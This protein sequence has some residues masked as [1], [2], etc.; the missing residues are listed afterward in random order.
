MEDAVSPAPQRA[1][2][3][4]RPAAWTPLPAAAVVALLVVALVTTAAAV[5]AGVR[6]TSSAMV[7]ACDGVNLRAGTSTFAPIKARLSTGVTLTVTGS[8][9]GSAWRAVCAGS[10]AGSGW[11]RVSHVNGRSVASLYG[12]SVLYAATGVLKNAPAA[13]PTPAPTPTPTPP[14]TTPAPTPTPAPSPSPTPSPPGMTI[15]GPTVTFFGRGWGHGV[16]LSQY[17]ARGRAFAGQSAAAILAHY[18]PGTTPW[19]IPTTTSVRVLLVDDLVPTTAS[20]V[21]VTGRGGTW[22][23]DGIAT[24]FP[25][26]GRLQLIPATGATTTWRLVVD[27]A[28]GKVLRQ[29]EAPADLRVRGTTAATLFQLPAAS[30]TYDLFRGTLRILRSGAKVDVVNELPMESYLRGVVPAEMSSSW[31]V[32]ARIAQTIAA[33]SYAAYR[34]RPGVSTFDVYPDTRS[35]V[36]L[37]VRV[38]TGAAS[39]VVADTSGRVLRSGTAIA[40]TLFH[41]T[42]G[43]AT[44]N[45]ENVFVS[46]TGA[47]VAGPV[48]YLRGS[49]DRDAK[50]VP[51]DA[52]SPYATWQ[53]RSYTLAQLSAILAAD[54]RTNV[55]TLKAIDLRNR[56]VSGRLISVTLVGS[57]GRTTVSG[58]VLVSAFNAHRP[59][60]DPPLRSTLLGLVPIP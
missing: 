25:A 31:P 36:Y 5:P 9:A 18:Y 60:A 39:K 28:T 26:D 19:S 30:K 20:P 55:G 32:E 58:D 48:S 29:G 10:R 56:G 40:N 44:E 50:G 47:R 51:Y 35:Q 46:A 54:Q 38:E 22:T 42:G 7:P 12:A 15:P 6:A 24:V 59:A 16:G 4:S 2:R 33:R 53:T 23:I 21:A 8:L 34:L 3:S 41:S 52:G 49:S 43:G 1:A 11:Y 14:T 17:G 27:D 13:A 37:G 45:N 57:T